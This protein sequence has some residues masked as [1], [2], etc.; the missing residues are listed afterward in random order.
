MIATGK[1]FPGHGDTQTN[2]HL[3]L[4]VV[5]VSRARLDSVELVP[6]R[7]AIA[8]GVRAIMTFHGA[9]PALDSSGLPGTLSSRVLGD[10]LRVEMGFK[11]III[12]DAMDMRGVLDQ[13]GAV[14]AAKRAVAAG[15]DILIQPLDV[16]QTIDAVAA[17]VTEGRYPESRLDASVRLILGAKRRMR[18]DRRKLVSP[19]S[20]RMI[21][22]DSAHAAAVRTVA[23]RSIT[24]VRDS[25]GLVPLGSRIRRVL[26]ISVARRT[27]FQAGQAFVSELRRFAP[28]VRHEFVDADDPAGK[29]TD[30]LAVADSVDMV[31]IGSYVAH[32]W[33]IASVSAPTAFV[34]FVN[35]LIV[36]R[37][38]RKPKPRTPVAVIAFGNPYLLQQIPK[39]PTYLVAWSGIPSSQV[40]AARALGGSVAITGQLPISIPPLVP[41]GAGLQR[42]AATAR[43]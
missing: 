29:L 39:V 17:G 4:P 9:M 8:A 35:K 22:G 16:T 26:S 15:A 20:A 36:P 3:A 1:H 31:V 6:F 11:G 32:R 28:S 24:L 7:A 13:F 38:G 30:L 18:L 19:D 41:L 10:L 42:P 40:A 23:E 43:D 27:D 25:A 12:S 5:N 14:E 37:K 34:D 2:S 21:V 33:D